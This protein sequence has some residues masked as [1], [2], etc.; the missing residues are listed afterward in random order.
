VRIDRALGYRARVAAVERTYAIDQAYDK[1]R[2]TERTTVTPAMHRIESEDPTRHLAGLGNR[3]KGKDRL[4]EKVTLDVEKKGRTVD[5]AFANV[6]DTIRY[7]FVYDEDHYTAGVY[8]DCER[9]ESAGFGSFD[10]RNSWD[11]EE[12]KGINS[13]WRIRPGPDAERKRAAVTECGRRSCRPPL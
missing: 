5:Q 6:K 2:D 11:E 13:R 10:R 4:I 1:I 3:L 8:A 9:L 12:Y 7:T